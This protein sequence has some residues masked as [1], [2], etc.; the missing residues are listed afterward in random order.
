MKKKMLRFFHVLIFEFS[1]IFFMVEFSEL[2]NRFIT[3]F[4]ES[5]NQ[6]LEV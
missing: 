6:R 5:N 3:V 4:K 1:Q 2:I